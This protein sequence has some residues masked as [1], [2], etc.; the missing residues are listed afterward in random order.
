[1]GDYADDK[2]F[3]GPQRPAASNTADGNL[4]DSSAGWLGAAALATVAVLIIRAR[5]EARARHPRRCVCG[6]DG[7]YLNRN[8]RW[9]S[10]G[11]RWQ[12]GR[13]VHKFGA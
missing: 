3:G 4:P 6:G 10:C 9:E 7:K 13:L 5:A 12:S 2:P 1:M 8:R 11:N